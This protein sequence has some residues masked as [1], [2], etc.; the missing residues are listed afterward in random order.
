MSTDRPTRS[1]G[2]RRREAL[3]QIREELE[4]LRKTEAQVAE[5]LGAMR[6]ARG[7]VEELMRGLVVE[8]EGLR[9]LVREELN[10]VVAGKP[11]PVGEPTSARKGDAPAGGVEGLFAGAAPGSNADAP[12]APPGVSPQEEM[13]APE[14]PEGVRPA[15]GLV[16]VATGS[17]LVVA[18][19][20]WLAVRAFQGGMEPQVISLGGDEPTPQAAPGEPPALD[21][22]PQEAPDEAQG[23]PEEDAPP[24]AER[25]F[26][27]LPAE[28]NQRAAIYDSLWMARSPLLSPLVERTEELAPDGAVTDATA[29]WRA[30]AQL[31][32][33]Q[34]DILRSALVQTVLRAS[35]DQGLQVDGQLLRN[36]CR[37][38]SC[39]ALLNLWESRGGSYGLPPVPA[40]APTNVD[41]M[42][43]AE[44]VIM[45]R[46]LERLYLGEEGT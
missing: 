6:A 8:E 29:R 16:G 33:L 5:S 1:G 37:G 30:G 4:R 10:A 17:V 26:V 43:R 35:V 46:E 44:N 24:A 3:R 31:T 42:R 12:T 28:P 14:T 18:V 7:R 45:L 2:E 40:D 11:T 13:E 32:P 39:S 9:Q 22:L 38:R 19:V 23:E 21:T 41:A 34:E 27:M 15:L 36:P 20:A 25:F